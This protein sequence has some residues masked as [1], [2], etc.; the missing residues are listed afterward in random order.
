MTDPLSP[1]PDDDLPLGLELVD[2]APPEAVSC[3][4]CGDPVEAWRS[5]CGSCG[6]T[7]TRR[8][9]DPEVP[10]DAVLDAEVVEVDDPFDVPVAE[11]ITDPFGVPLRPRPPPTR[12]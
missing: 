10:A 1:D 12:P 3:R 9:A 8:R 5:A 11:V 4:R 6:S 2:D 7:L